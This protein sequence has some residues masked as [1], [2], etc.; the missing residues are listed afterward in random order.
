MQEKLSIFFHSTP[1]IDNIPLRLPKLIINKK[2]K[3]LENSQLLRK[4]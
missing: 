3:E 1:S 2:P 4:A